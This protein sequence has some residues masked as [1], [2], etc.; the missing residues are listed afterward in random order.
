MNRMPKWWRRFLAFVVGFGLA[1]FAN[2]LSYFV[3]SSGYGVIPVNDGVVAIGFPLVMFERGGSDGRDE[4]Y[5][6]AAIGN[7]LLALGFAAWVAACRM[8][9]ESV[10]DGRD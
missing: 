9:R 6:K 5:W 7:L 1:C 4:F 10:R 3:L 2:L 8:K